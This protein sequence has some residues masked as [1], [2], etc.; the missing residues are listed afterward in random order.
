LR[1]IVANYT[2]RFDIVILHIET[3]N[4]NVS[5]LI[6]VT[7][8]SGKILSYKCYYK[9]VQGFCAK[10]ENENKEA[11]LSTNPEDFDVCERTWKSGE[12]IIKRAFSPSKG[13]RWVISLGNIKANQIKNL[14]SSG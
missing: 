12:I 11:P 3:N 9:F 6:P 13:D 10:V 1:K 14:K 4:F 7:D 5:D 2:K 8:S